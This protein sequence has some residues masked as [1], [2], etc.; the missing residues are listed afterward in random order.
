MLT[1]FQVTRNISVG[2][3]DISGK[4]ALLPFDMYCKTY[5]DPLP[6]VFGHIEPLLVNMHGVEHGVKLHC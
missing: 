6:F 5:W 2:T 4:N 3:S 1:T